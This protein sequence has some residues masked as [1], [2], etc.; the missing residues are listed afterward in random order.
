MSQRELGAYLGLSR[1]NV[2]RQLGRLRDAGV[3]SVTGTSITIKDEE[4]LAA[5][6]SKPSAD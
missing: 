2:N 5:L 4:V 3:V 6:A 1:E